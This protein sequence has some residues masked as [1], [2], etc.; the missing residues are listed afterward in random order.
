MEVGKDQ[1]G[2]LG[3]AWV[4]ARSCVAVFRQAIGCVRKQRHAGYKSLLELGRSI[5]KISR[6]GGREKFGCFSALLSAQPDMD[7][8]SPPAKLSP[9]NVWI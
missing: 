6:E 4:R 9:N 5:N 1:V 2:Y 8:G 7:G 3:C